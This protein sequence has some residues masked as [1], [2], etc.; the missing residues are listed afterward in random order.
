MPS[1]ALLIYV[2]KFLD[3]FS[4]YSAE[5]TSAHAG[6]MLQALAG[7]VEPS[8][9][10]AGIQAKYQQMPAGSSPYGDYYSANSDSGVDEPFQTQDQQVCKISTYC[11]FLHQ[12]K[13]LG[14]SCVYGID[15]KLFY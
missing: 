11:N 1:H 15:W 12:L 10:T 4:S 7:G 13:T 3:Y 9:M 5:G 6:G 2:V 8:Y 14:R